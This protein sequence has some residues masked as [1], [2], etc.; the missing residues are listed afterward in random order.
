MKPIKLIFTLLTF[1]LLI[2][3]G[4]CQ[5]EADLPVNLSHALHLTDSIKIDGEQRVFIWIYADHPEYKP[6][7]APGEG[8]ACADDVGRFLE[9][10]EQAILDY[11]KKEFVDL[12]KKMTRFLLYMEKEGQ[13]Y[14][15]IFADGS[16][17]KGHINSK[18]DFGFWAVRGLRGLAASYRILQ[19]HAPQSGLMDS[20]KRSIHRSEK[21]YTNE[22]LASPDDGY[23]LK[24]APDMT[25]ELLLVLTKLHETGD[26]NYKSE[27]QNIVQS[28][29]KNQFKKQGHELNGMYFCW[30]N[31]WHSWGNNQ[32]LAL[33]KAYQITGN[34]EILGSV[35]RWA[36]NF[37]RF[38]IDNN[39]PANIEIQDKAKYK[40]EI[41]PQIA[42]GITSMYRGIVELNK[43]T[44]QE[45]YKD[46]AERIF[47]WYEGENLAGVQMYD[48]ETGRCFDGINKENVNKNSGAESTIEC[49]LA[50][51]TQH[52]YLKRQEWQK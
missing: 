29:V 15:F 42:Y 14:N 43:I 4:S 46:Q 3:T 18:L 13:W 47:G 16:I 36:D 25:S 44:N 41:Y 19:K 26:Y 32:A 35:K 8:I 31:I 20:I 51:F 21:Y 28:L 34:Q 23:L 52:K 10:L 22:A 9:V 40:I 30:K 37:L 45:K 17:N 48:P 50:L 12:S 6:A 39:F 27:I 5:K 2:F 1:V 11:N 24:Q 33:M 38:V 49:L 7:K